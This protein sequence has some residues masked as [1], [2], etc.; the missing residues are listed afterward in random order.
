MMPA[1]GA[2]VWGL[3]YSGVYQ[4]A[5]ERQASKGGGKGEGMQVLCHGRE[6]YE[7]TFWAMAFSVWIGCGLWMWAWKG[8]GGWSRRGIAV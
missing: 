1:F 5:A 4:W 3:V 7:S 2:T 6:C 8:P